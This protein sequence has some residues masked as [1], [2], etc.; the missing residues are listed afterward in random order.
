ME[1]ILSIIIP[2]Y[3]TEKYINICLPY[4]LDQRIMDDIELLIISDGSKDR[5]V[6][7]AKKYSVLELLIKKMGDMVQL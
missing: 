5:T 2:S 7:I 1:K 6:E 4:F 3:N